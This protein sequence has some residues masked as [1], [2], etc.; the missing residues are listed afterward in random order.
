MMS[1]IGILF[2]LGEKVCFTVL[3]S[4]KK[5]DPGAQCGIEYYILYCKFARMQKY[6]FLIFGIFV[7]QGKKIPTH[8]IN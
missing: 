4:L 1:V 6:G 7:D 8:V 5:Y 2:A 3:R